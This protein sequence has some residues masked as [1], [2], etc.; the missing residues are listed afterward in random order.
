MNIERNGPRHCLREDRDGIA[1]VWID[2]P[3]VNAASSGR[4][5][6][7]ARGHLVQAADADPCRSRRHG[8]PP[9]A[10]PHL[11]CRRRHPR[12]WQAAAVALF[13]SKC[14]LCASSAH[15]A[16][17]SSPRVHGTALGGG[18]RNRRSPHMAASHRVDAKFGLPEVK[19]GIVPGAWRHAAPVA[20]NVGI[21]KPPWSMASTSGRF[22][23]REGCACHSALI[24]RHRGRAN[25]VT[26]P[27]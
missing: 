23:Q 26:K 27:L 16:S 22:D 19:L 21:P 7:R 6:G 20:S 9:A 8:H 4:A 10:G 12:I 11:H 24:D 25:L 3:P 13:S 15:A 17:R 1:I 5:R 14:L 2:N 18:C